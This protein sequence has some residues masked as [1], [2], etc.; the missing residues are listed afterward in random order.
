MGSKIA[1]ILML[2]ITVV[3]IVYLLVLVITGGNKEKLNFKHKREQ[4]RQQEIERGVITRE[5]RVKEKEEL[6]IVLAEKK[7]EQK[8][9]DAEYDSAV[10]E[11]IKIFK[12]EKKVAKEKYLAVK[13]EYD[14]AYA[15]Y[16]KWAEENPEKVVKED[17]DAYEFKMEE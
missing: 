15:E 8:A 16:K 5:D 1:V 4:K 12:E 9:A 2:I 14:Q 17:D 6:K 7:A 13:K 10:K 11:N 3:L